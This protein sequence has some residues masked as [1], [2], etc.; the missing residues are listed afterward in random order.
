MSWWVAAGV[1]V[2]SV[3]VVA[4][5]ALFVAGRRFAARELL[6]VVPNLIRLFR[7]LARDPRTG[8]SSKVVLWITAI[9]LVS[10]IDLI[11]EFLPVVGPLDDVVIAALAL[12]FVMRR[13]GDGVVRAHWRGDPR[14]LELLLRFAARRGDVSPT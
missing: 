11:P 5:A 9:W 13:A 12:R 1:T 14:S 10:P 7:D 8:R 6:T 2:L 4:I 3:W